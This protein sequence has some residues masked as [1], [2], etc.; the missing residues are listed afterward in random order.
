MQPGQPGVSQARHGKVKNKYLAEI[1]EWKRGLL[2][3]Y[4]KPRALFSDVIKLAENNWVGH[5]DIIGAER[6]VPYHDML[7]AGIECDGVSPMNNNRSANSN[8]VAEGRG[9]TG[10]T[11]NAAL[12]MIIY[13][14]PEISW[15]SRGDVPFIS[16]FACAS[17][18]K[19]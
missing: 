18:V 5:C 13:F 10:T 11:A 15:F 4:W 7:I 12:Q 8:C 2:K 19:P 3:E 6:K 14:R 17:I 1:D 9:K 16:P